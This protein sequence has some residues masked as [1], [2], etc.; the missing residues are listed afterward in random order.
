MSGSRQ[1]EEAEQ[2]WGQAGAGLG[3]RRRRESREDSGPPGEKGLPGE[4]R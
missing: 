1:R 3:D 4:I 2:W